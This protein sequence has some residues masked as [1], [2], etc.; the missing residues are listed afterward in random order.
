MKFNSINNFITYITSVFIILITF[1]V[2]RTLPFSTSRGDVNIFFSFLSYIYRGW[3]FL[4]LVYFFS[5]LLRKGL[6]TKIYIKYL[7]FIFLFSSLLIFN[8]NFWDQRSSSITLLLLSTPILYFTIY[9]KFDYYCFFRKFYPLIFV[10]LIIQLLFFRYEG[11]PVLGIGD[12]N[13]SGL[14]C[15]FFLYI[16]ILLNKK[17]GM[18]FSF[19]TIIFFL[20]RTQ[21]MSLLIFTTL[22]F[23]NSIKSY[24]SKFKYSIIYIVSFIVLILIGSY[25][26]VRLSF[27]SSYIGYFGKLFSFTDASNFLRFTQN[28]K[29]I[30]EIFIERSNNYIFGFNSPEQFL[31]MGNKIFPHNDLL[32]LFVTI[33]VTGV[34]MYFTLVFKEIQNFFSSN[35]EF[36]M[37]LIPFNLLLGIYNDFYYLI[38][39]FMILSINKSKPKISILSNHD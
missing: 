37:A 35:I 19:L 21:M 11:M 32:M 18:I 15:I 25:L 36:C 23:N 39:L 12:P 3:L 34:I 13:Y 28:I 10:S 16:S 14:L 38:L 2:P 6:L 33:G 7:V 8:F 4:V 24:I 26:L 29:I 9:S 22:Y 30:T 5:I 27:E 31:E 17:Y 20:S 1:I